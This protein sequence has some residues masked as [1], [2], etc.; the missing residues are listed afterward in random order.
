MVNNSQK[1]SKL[2]DVGLKKKK[3]K[4]KGDRVNRPQILR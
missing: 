4:I 3:T 2:D 1:I